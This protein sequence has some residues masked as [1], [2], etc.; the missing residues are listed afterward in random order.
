L[1]VASEGLCLRSLPATSSAIDRNAA[2][3]A[4]PGGGSSWPV[5][6]AKRSGF[7]SAS[8]SP[9]AALPSASSEEAF[10]EAQSPSRRSSSRKPRCLER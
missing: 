7:S 4:T 8:S 1:L 3:R 2:F 9:R 5:S 6:Q 10:R